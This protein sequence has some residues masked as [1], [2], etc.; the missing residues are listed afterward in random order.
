MN[1]AMIRAYKELHNLD[2]SL[3]KAQILK[4]YHTNVEKLK[5]LTILLTGEQKAMFYQA[6]MAVQKPINLDEDALR[7]I[8]DEVGKYLDGNPHNRDD[9]GI[10]EMISAYFYNSETFKNLTNENTVVITAF[11][12][13]MGG[14]TLRIAATVKL[15]ND[16]VINNKE[17]IVNTAVQ[18]NPNFIKDSISR[19]SV[20]YDIIDILA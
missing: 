18:L 5:V 16:M 8:V 2:A 7:C 15:T 1:S 3:S 14:H 10:S 6:D 4:H 12:D 19:N 11:K 17:D 13:K 9:I 20:Y